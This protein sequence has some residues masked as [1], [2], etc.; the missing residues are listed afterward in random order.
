LR[1]DRKVELLAAHH[2]EGLRLLSMEPD[3]AAVAAIDVSISLDAA[4]EFIDIATKAR[5]AGRSS[6]FV[7]VEGSEVTG[8]CRLIGIL[9]V[10]RLIVGVRYAYRGRGNG[11]FLVRH[12]LAHAF[13][14]LGVE[15][16]T[17]T[18]PCLRLVSRFGRVDGNRL[19]RAEWNAARAKSS[20]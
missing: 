6:V 16:V 5:E 2:A 3:L 13:E 20:A 14:T 7:L 19:T 1:P 9:G 15:Q 8:V 18:G 4:A 11:A 10:P 12:V 17:A